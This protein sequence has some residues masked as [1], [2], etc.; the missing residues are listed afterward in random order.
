MLRLPG[1]QQKKRQVG[2]KVF[3]FQDPYFLLLLLILPF[4][5]YYFVYKRRKFDSFV[6]YSSFHNLKNVKRS[7]S[8]V[9]QYTPFALRCFV[10]ASLIFAL[11]RPQHGTKTTEIISEGIDIVI[12]IDTSGSMRALD[13]TIQKERKNRLEIIKLVV[14][15][16]IK[17]RK[18]DRVGMV[19]FGDD[20][21][22]QCPLTLDHGILISLLK[23]LKIGMAGEKTAIGS[24]I[25]TSVKRLK[26]LKSKSRVIILLSDGEN[27]AGIDPLKAAEIAKG[28]GMKIYTIGVGSTGE[29]PVLE[30]D[31]FFG[32]TYRY[33]YLRLDEELL[34]KIASTTDGRYYNARN[35]IELVKIYDEIN[36]LEKSEI[37]TKE[38]MD[39]NE[40][41]FLWVFVALI[42]LGLEII[43]INTAFRKIP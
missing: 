10:L 6:R 15:E 12:A 11:A 31:G 21:Y 5:V 36:R 33:A 30:V 37:K 18:D 20:A 23:K 17:L 4:L 7:R 1:L 9:K 29:V 32:K 35:T 43:L 24:A 40:K 41:Y 39:F 19:V 34:R 28:Y 3:R 42:L 26:T 38:Y 25:G 13:F 16:F 22:T 2:L 27:T 8:A 14:E